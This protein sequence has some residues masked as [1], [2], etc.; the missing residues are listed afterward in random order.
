M[1][2]AVLNNRYRIIR[3]LGKGGFGKTF[4]AEDTHLPSQRICVI[5]QLKP[6]IEKPHVYQVMQERFAREAAILEEL[7]EENNQIPKLYA[8]FVENEQFYLVQELIEGLTLSQKLRQEGYFNENIIQNILIDIL[9]VL[10]YIHSK[11]IIHRDIKPGNIIYREKDAKPVLIDFGIAKEIINPILDNGGRFTNTIITGTPGFMPPEQAAGRPVFA[12]DIYSLG[13]TAISLLSGKSP[14]S[15]EHNPQTGETIWESKTYISNHLRKVLD[16]ATKTNS[17]DRFPNAKAMLEALHPQDKLFS[18]RE[19]LNKELSKQELSKQ[20]LSNKELSNQELSNKELFKKYLLD[21][22]PGNRILSNQISLNQNLTERQEELAKFERDIINST[23]TQPPGLSDI[24][25]NTPPSSHHSK[26]SYRNRQILLNKVKNYWVKGVLETSLHGIALIELGLENRLDALAH[27]WGM[28]WETKE[29]TKQQLKEGTK[30]TDLFL[31]LGTGRS[32]LI[33]GE[34]GAGKTTTLLEI[35]RDLIRISQHN[36]NQPIPVVFNLSTWSNPKI[37]I[38]KWLIQELNTNYQVSKEIAKNWVE[39]QQLLL[40]LDGLDEVNSQYR[41]ACIAA[42][43]QFCQNY[44]ETEIIVCS[45]IKD[46]QNLSNRLH[47][48]SAVYIQPLTLDRIHHYLQNVG[49]ELSAVNRALQTDETLQELAKS[50]LMLS[51]MTLAYQGISITELPGMT[52]EEHRQHLFDKYIER[53]FERRITKS[54]Y[55]KEQSIHWLSWLARKLQERSQTVFLIE[56]MQPDLLPKR[57]YHFYRLCSLAVLTGIGWFIGIQIIDPAKVVVSLTF[58]IIIFWL[59]FGLNRINPVETLK[60][61]WKNARN[62]L[63]KGM[64]YGLILGLILKVNSN[65]RSYDWEQV[66][67]YITNLGGMQLIR[68]IFFGLSLGLFFVIVRGLTGPSIQTFIKPNQGIRQSAKNSLVFGLIGALILRLTAIMLGWTT[69]GWTMF[70]FSFGMVVGGVEACIKHLIIR[71]IL[72]L[73]GSI[74]WNYA[75][76]LDY[77][78]ERIFLQKVGGGYIFVHRLLLEHFAQM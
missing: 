9:P 32:L 15:L 27:P 77:A 42:I 1:I 4:L 50:P 52:L 29:Q 13:M 45:R 7:G 2:P 67:R 63:V 58:I 25:L 31:Q 37:S 78:T 33:L 61:S 26:Q 39:N 51:I 19:L 76:F 38:D 22:V 55:S 24:N 10:D 49:A 53:M 3:T 66:I 60:W 35:T 20:E 71:I 30:V 36:I 18:N 34:P 62:N 56:R 41:D 11:G 46:Y 69:R 5:K 17:S 70:G 68:G 54:S 57:W 44:G 12:S 75:R 21:V 40:L 74:P 6:V 73:R 16:R 65:L 8:Y 23:K 59:Y 14:E 64:I 48:Q 28:L 47:F 72:F 43:N